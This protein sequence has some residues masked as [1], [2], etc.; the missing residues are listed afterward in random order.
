MEITHTV[1]PLDSP[2]AW[3]G[4]ECLLG[5]ANLDV[6]RNTI[7]HLRVLNAKSYVLEDPY[8]DRDYSADYAQF[9]ALTFHTHERF[10]KRVHFF[11]Q[12]I[13]PLLRRPLTTDQLD[14]LGGFAK[15]TYCG[16]C[17]IRPLS[18]APFQVH[19]GQ[20]IEHQC[21]VVEVMP[22]QTSLNDILAFEQPVHGRVEIVLVALAKGERFGQRVASGVGRQAAGSGQF[23]LGVEDACDDEGQHPVALR[24]VLRREG[25]SSRSLRKVPSTAAT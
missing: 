25:A 15:N 24:T 19:R 21:P 7:R 4:L 20:V 17:V 12:D 3:S 10:C 22:G 13:S 8:I 6:V 23:R 5:G 18:A 16:F 1:E 11:S 2:S 14:R 9:Y